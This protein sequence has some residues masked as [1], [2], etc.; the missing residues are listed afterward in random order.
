MADMNLIAS[1]YG[2]AIV[3]TFSRALSGDMGAIIELVLEAAGLILFVVAF[4]WWLDR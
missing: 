3:D 2:R 4:K 1:F